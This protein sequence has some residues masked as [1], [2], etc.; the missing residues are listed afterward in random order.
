MDHT[1]TGSYAE[2]VGLYRK[3]LLLAYITIFYNVLEGAVSVLFG[4]EDETLALF[5][6]GVDSFVEVI[7]GIGIWHMIQRLS[8]H[9]DEPQDR[10]EQTALHITGSAFYLLAIG[11]MATASINLFQG[12]RPVTTFW[13]VVISLISIMTMWL[14]IHFKVKVGRKLQS[15]AILA[16]ANC[17]KTCLYLSFFLLVASAGYELTGIGGLDSLGA[18]AIAIFAFREGR[19]A[20]E[21]ARGKSCA[22]CTDCAPN[23]K[24]PKTLSEERPE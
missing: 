2:R 13:G 21:K 10:F 17:T 5:G 19:E 4:L 16:D 7:S 9:Q 1:V 22:C 24:I 18:I 3:A 8:R 12:H 15:D 14:L 6:F 23:K 20:F 11:L